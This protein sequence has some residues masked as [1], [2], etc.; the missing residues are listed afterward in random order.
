MYNS[1]EISLYEPLNPK[2]SLAGEV[3]G[4]KA[5]AI[6]DG[7]IEPRAFILNRKGETIEVISSQLI[8]TQEDLVEL[9]PDASKFVSEAPMQPADFSSSTQNNY[10]RRQKHGSV[11]DFYSF[12]EVFKP[13]SWHSRKKPA[14]TS[15]NLATVNKSRSHKHSHKSNDLSPRIFDTYGVLEQNPLS[16]EGYKQL[17][18]GM[19]SYEQFKVSRLE[20]INR[21]TIHDP[22]S[23][24][25]IELEANVRNKV[26][27]AYK[28]IMKKLEQQN[29][30]DE[31]KGN[32]NDNADDFPVFIEEEEIT[33]DS[34]TIEIKDAFY[35]YTNPPTNTTISFANVRL[36]LIQIFNMNI[37][38]ETIMSFL[39]EDTYSSLKTDQTISFSFLKFS[40]LYFK[41][42]SVILDSDKKLSDYSVSATD[43]V[44]DEFEESKRSMIEDPKS[45]QSDMSYWTSSAGKDVEVPKSAAPLDL[46]P[47]DWNLNET[48][49]HDDFTTE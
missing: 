4:L 17:Y 30:D 3:Q 22:R 14:T 35:S 41:M 25:E 38:N 13:R 43:D 36:A 12:D 21:F 20:A 24:E 37:K 29:K 40:D 47:L 7:P 28:A 2:R 49:L 39:D 46:R 6:S 45:P 26:K 11:Y 31:K 44:V 15:L 1:F 16:S 5:T 19:N 18:K 9:S 33:E 32:E 27:L 23:N 48:S 10:F 34:E 8:T 42:K